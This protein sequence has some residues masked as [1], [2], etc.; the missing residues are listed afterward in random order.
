MRHCASREN[1]HVHIKRVKLALPPNGE[2]KIT[3]KQFGNIEVF[4]GKKQKN[5]EKPPSQLQF[6]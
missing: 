4:Y 6:F 1:S 2:V 3:D 5:I